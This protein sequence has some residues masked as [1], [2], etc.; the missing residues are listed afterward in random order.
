MKKVIQ[1]IS[2]E[3]GEIVHEVDVTGRSER[4]VDRVESGIN[5]NLNHDQYYTL[6]AEIEDRELIKATTNEKN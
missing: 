1:V 3:S 4:N 2:Y 6:E 5:R